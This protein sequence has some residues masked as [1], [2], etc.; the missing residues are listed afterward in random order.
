[1]L[2]PAASPPS[3]L[4]DSRPRES[5]LL[6]RPRGWVSQALEVMGLERGLHVVVESLGRTG[7]G[8][9]G[10]LYHAGGLVVLLSL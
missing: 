7:T 5:P 2:P 8:T 10:A 3:S 9:G 6:H 4:K 1:M